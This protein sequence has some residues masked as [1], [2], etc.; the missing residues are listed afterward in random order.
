MTQPLLAIRG[1]EAAYGSLQVL[2]GVDLSVEQ[3]EIVSIV[4]P[5][6]AGKSTV[7]KAVVGLVTVKAGTVSFSGTNITA[8]PIHRIPTLGIGYVPQG[9]IV[10]SRMS[11]TE[12]LELGAFLEKDAHKRQ[13]AVKTVYEQFPQLYERR[14][15]PAGK[16][17]GGEQQMLA[18]GRALMMN[19]RLLI[20][21]EPSLG[22]SPKY[23]DLI[24]DQLL[25]L[26]SQGRTLLMVEQNAAR[27][28][29]LSDRGYAL[30]LGRN[31]FTDT[32][33]ALLANKE[34][35]QMYLGGA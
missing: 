16:L 20:L 25:A 18:I 21:D 22:L 3:G 12:N 1:L 27:A 35:Q 7:I 8:I 19:P 31:R 2:F 30:E 23:V 5:N 13:Q 24:T 26:K 14:K 32:G 15:Q 6:G 11:V 10:F 33:V 34:V 17:S 9:R 29:E 28:L 4:G